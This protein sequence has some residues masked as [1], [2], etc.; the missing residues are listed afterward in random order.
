MIRSLKKPAVK[1]SR[2]CLAIPKIVSGCIWRWIRS[3]ASIREVFRATGCFGG[4]VG[5]TDVYDVMADY[6]YKTS[7][8]KDNYIQQGLVMNDGSVPFTQSFEHGHFGH[9]ELLIRYIPSD[10]AFKLLVTEFMGKANEMAVKD[11]FGVPGHCFSDAQ[12]DFFGPH[13]MNYHIWS[14]KLKKSFDPNGVSDPTHY[15][16]AKD[17]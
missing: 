2:V 10:K 8:L 1:S 6:I 16:S 11:H 4:E 12:H 9:G 13:V 3:T 7:L 14:R 5:G 17:V 15:I